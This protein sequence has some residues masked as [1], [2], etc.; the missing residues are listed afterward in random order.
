MRVAHTVLH[1]HFFYTHIALSIMQPF[2]SVGEDAAGK[3]KRWI[4]EANQRKKPLQR[5]A[6]VEK[7]RARIHFRMLFIRVLNL[8]M[9]DESRFSH[10]SCAHFRLSVGGSCS[11]RIYSLSSSKKRN[12]VYHCKKESACFEMRRFLRAIPSFLCFQF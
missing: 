1:S 6:V 2:V 12:N 5:R 7:D 9:N 4:F 3:E 10:A 11:G 8:E